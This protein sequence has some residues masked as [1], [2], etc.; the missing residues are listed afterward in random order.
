MR[1]A[2]PAELPGSCPAEEDSIARMVHHFGITPIRRASIKI[3]SVTGRRVAYT[4]TI[5]GMLSNAKTS[6]RVRY[7][8]GFKGANCGVGVIK[9]IY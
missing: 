2:P 6:W 1:E 3:V 5:M 8:G 4:N 9:V 7:K